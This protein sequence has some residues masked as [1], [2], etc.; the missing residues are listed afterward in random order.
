[1]DRRSLSPVQAAHRRQSL[2]RAILSMIACISMEGILECEMLETSV[3]GDT[4]YEFVSLK[5]EV[6]LVQS[7]LSFSTYDN[8]HVVHNVPS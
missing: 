4:F 1:M 5:L 7:S 3:D 6:H 2:L 8:L